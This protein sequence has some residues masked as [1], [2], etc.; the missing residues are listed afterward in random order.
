MI[1]ICVLGA[2]ERAVKWKWRESMDHSD[3]NAAVIDCFTGRECHLWA[4]KQI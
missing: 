2:K 4:E 3:D 1:I